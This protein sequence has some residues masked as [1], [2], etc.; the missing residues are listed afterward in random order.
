LLEEA[1]EPL[2]K[3]E[4]EL[5][6]SATISAE[7]GALDADIEAESKTTDTASG[8]EREVEA[9]SGEVL[10][11]GKQDHAPPPVIL[12]DSVAREVRSFDR[13]DIARIGGALIAFQLNPARGRVLKENPAYRV[14]DAGRGISLIVRPLDKTSRE[15]RDRY[16]VLAVGSGEEGHRASGLDSLWR[17]VTRHK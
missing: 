7:P 17:E 13:T 2:A 5:L 15:D 10:S 12:T 16:V 6:A 1:D 14:L 8:H 3:W 11:V 4:E 9:V